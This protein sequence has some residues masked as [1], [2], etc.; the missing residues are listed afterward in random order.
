MS[1]IGLAPSIKIHS[2]STTDDV[3][4]STHSDDISRSPTSFGDTPIVQRPLSFQAF[5]REELSNSSITTP[6]FSPN[7]ALKD[8]DVSSMRTL[9]DVRDQV[10]EKLAVRAIRKLK[11][12]DNTR[13]AVTLTLAKKEDAEFLRMVA[14][15]LRRILAEKDHLMA[16]ATTGVGDTSLVVCGSSPA[17]VHRA[18]LLV[19]SKFIGRIQGLYDE[20]TLWIA[21]VHGVDWTPYD[22]AA[23][24]DV[25]QKSARNLIDPSQPPP[26]S[27]SIAE[28]LAAARTRLQRL[29]A[30][31]A[32]EELQDTSLI[33]PV[34]LVDIRPQAQRLQHGSIPGSLIIERNVLEWRFDPRS[35]D[36]RLDIATRYDLRIIVIC[37]EGY[38]SSL[39]AASL[40]DL[41]LLNATDIIGGFKAW[42]EEGLPFELESSDGAV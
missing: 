1:T 23:L 30:R 28:I 21:R 39:A 3:T 37:Q 41:G 40:Q 18:S 33:M 27:C 35:L 38:T 12:V 24:W 9:E 4:R 8:D 7:P 6:I 36:G 16:V 34:L 5:H 2:P 11:V 26:G 22:E 17:Q 14:I 19:A 25:M 13:V 10:A 42:K 20:G 29:T 31:Q 15:H 32:F